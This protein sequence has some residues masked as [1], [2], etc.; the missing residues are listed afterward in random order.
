MP[1]RRSQPRAVALGIVGVVLAL[2]AMLLVSWLGSRG[3]VDLTFGGEEFE[4]GR[5]E[6]LAAEI[7]DRGPFLFRN[8]AGVDRHV[9]V[10]HLGDDPDQGWLTV[11]ARAPE[12]TDE[13]CYLEVDGDGFRD[14]C[15]GT[16]Y[17]ADGDGLQHY[18]TE[19]R[20]GRVFVDLRS[21]TER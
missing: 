14:P 5:T 18:P 15:S 21:T 13:S 12:Q 1:R 17:P 10:Q 7:D 9:Y 4:V 6:R 3:D 19:V 8:P 2:G 20:D 11:G 16:E